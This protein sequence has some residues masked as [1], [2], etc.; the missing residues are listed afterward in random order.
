M[1]RNVEYERISPRTINRFP[2]VRRL[3]SLFCPKELIA[4]TAFRGTRLYD[5]QRRSSRLGPEI[6]E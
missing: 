4:I 5:L 1:D 6:H 3:A 2:G